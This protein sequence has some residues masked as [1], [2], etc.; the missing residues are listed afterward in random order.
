VVSSFQYSTP[1][2]YCEGIRMREDRIV[3]QLEK[4]VASGRI[5]ED[6]A[7]HLRAAQGTS[8]MGTVMGEIRARHAS[9]H[10]ESAVRAGEMSREEADQQLGL[11]KTGEHPKGLRAR[12]RQ[13]RKT[14]PPL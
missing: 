14:T 12:L 8:E 5:T 6:E 1:L 13:H 10:L 2:G 4:M 7:A 3:E 11:I 9:P